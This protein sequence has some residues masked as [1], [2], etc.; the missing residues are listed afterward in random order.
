MA[1]SEASAGRN[2]LPSQID[3]DVIISWSNP[4]CC[5]T[6]LMYAFAQRQDADAFDEPLYGAWL[7]ATGVERPY[8]D[9]VWKDQGFHA[10][11]PC[12]NVIFGKREKKY[13][14]IKLISK[15]NTVTPISIFSRTRRQFLLVRDPYEVLR[16][17]AAAGEKERQEKSATGDTSPG[18]IPPPS[19]HELGYTALLEIY[20]HLLVD[21]PDRAPLVVLSNDLINHPDP[22]LRLLCERLDIPF[23]R[24]ML[25]WPAGPKP[26]DGAW[27]K[28]WYGATWKTTGFV[29]DGA[30][31]GG[32]GGKGGAPLPL[33]YRKVLGMCQPIWDFL[34]SKAVRP[35]LSAAVGV[36]RPLTAGGGGEKEGEG[37]KEEGT[38]SFVQDRRNEDVLIGVRE[39]VYRTFEF[40]HR[41]VA[42]LPVFSSGFLL[43][44]GVWE[45]FRVLHGAL[46]FA[47][48]HLQRLYTGAAFL[49]MHIDIPPRDLLRLVYATL[50]ANEGM[51]TPDADDVHVRLMVTRGLKPTPYQNPKITI[52]DVDIVVAP[53]FKKVTKQERGLKL[54]T[55]WVRRGRPDVQ[56][57]ALSSHS[58]INCILGCVSAN[59][60]GADEALMLD[61]D[62]FVVTCNSVNFFIV[63]H[64]TP[65]TPATVLTSPC[66][67]IHRGITRDN[68]VHL[69]HANNI[70]VREERFTLNDV[71][72]AREAFVTGTFGGVGWVGWVD[73]RPIGRTWEWDAPVDGAGWGKGE[74]RKGEV[75]ERLEKLYEELK[76]AE[77]AKGRGL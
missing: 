74:P 31:G 69:C 17:W 18:V 62:G 3:D 73:G 28:W 77:A 11:S 8:L 64:P 9:E 72:G 48:I 43:G 26:Y 35:D 39:G 34:K 55:S 24:A 53:E 52:G 68:I 6:A 56:D 44:D 58:K 2:S 20:N 1:E 51:S 67:H 10:I 25:S 49:G 61:E 32:A 4:R 63:T 50:D 70:P 27:G 21:H 75:T 65:T 45:G 57:P 46:L 22:T 19:V 15:F 60:V 42:K 23:D 40:V 71:Y 36:P 41:P 37:K 38:H 5:S 16:S 59:T 76:E 7:K 13:R 12:D 30:G 29:G 54:V 33:E 47:Q 14:Y 66:H